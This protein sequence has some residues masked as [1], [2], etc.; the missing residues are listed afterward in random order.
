MNMNLNRKLNDDEDVKISRRVRIPK[1]EQK[2]LLNFNNP[3]QH[4]HSNWKLKSIKKQKD[5]KDIVQKSASILYNHNRSLNSQL[6]GSENDLYRNSFYGLF[7][8]EKSL[9][10]KATYMSINTPKLISRYQT[11]HSKKSMST[12]SSNKL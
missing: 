3:I 1:I 10:P 11:V 9:I 5:L 2:V 6:G 12:Y 4:N 8:T 7:Q